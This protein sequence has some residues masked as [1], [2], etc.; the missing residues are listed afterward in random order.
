MIKKYF[1]FIFIVAIAVACGEKSP[2]EKAVQ[3]TANNIDS[4][5]NLYPDS[6]PLIVFRGNEALKQYRFFDALADGAKAFRLDSMNTQTRMLYA[7]ALNNKENRTVEEVLTAQRHFKYVLFK[8]PK[9]TDALVATAATYRYMQDVD[10]AFKYVNEALKVD[11]KKREAYA[12]KG[13][14]YLDMENYALAKSSYETAIQQD[15]NFYEAYFHLAALYHRED[16][17]ICL[18]YYQTAYE[19]NQSD[20]E[21]LYSYAYALDYFQ[22][23]DEAKVLYRKMEHEKEKYYRARGYFHLGYLKQNEE[24]DIDSAIY[25]YTQAIN[26]LKGYVEAYHNRGMCYERKGMKQEAKQEYL[27]ALKYDDKFQLS[28]D[29]FN[30]LNK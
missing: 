19:L 6:V 28:I 23:F 8:E 1:V 24:K 9:N 2:K 3:P 25:F 10:N 22:K 27:E 7:Q 21:F 17:P 15:P 20:P 30:K 14:L 26:N 13:S 16:N 5:L 12:L 18:E 29:A 11:A 4:L